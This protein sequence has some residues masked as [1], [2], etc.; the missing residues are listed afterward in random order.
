MNDDWNLITAKEAAEILHIKP[1]TISG[2]IFRNKLPFPVY[3]IGTRM[4][5]FKRTDIIAYLEKI[6]NE[7]A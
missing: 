6:R 5:R 4:L 1:S 7:Q 2:W 3:R